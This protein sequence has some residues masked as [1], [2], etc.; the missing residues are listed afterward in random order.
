MRLL[1]ATL[2]AFLLAVPTASAALVYVKT[3]ASG[4]PTI[5][6][7][8]NDGS[9]PRRLVDGTQP[10]I[11]GD[12]ATVA[13]LRASGSRTEL[14]L[15]PTAGG[16]VRAL[17]TSSSI[18]S[19][20]FS[21]DAKLVAAEVG[22]RRLMVFETDTGRMGTLAT[23]FIKG[24]SFAPDSTRMVFGRGVDAT[25]RG[26]ADVYK[27]SV[28]GGP[29]RRL[30]RDGRSLLP[31]WGTSVIPA[32]DVWGMD[33]GGRQER[34]ITVTKVPSGVS[35]LLPIEWSADGRRLIAQYVGANV[36]V[37]F[38]INP[39]S[40]GT[41]SLRRKVAFDLASDGSAVLMQSGGIDPA[42]RHNVYAAPYAGGES[43]L[44]VRNASFPDWSR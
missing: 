37:G 35:G 23:G 10:Q 21:P 24:L 13:F 11:S 44:L 5:F 9:D 27:V 8:G 25:A 1:L 31:I 32:Y 39:N 12:G 17:V 20:T 33:V 28:R 19:V 29:A 38:T 3:P 16:P 18:E 41:R 40:G 30:T 42:A 22:G 14:A 34:R 7:A 2:V 4:A 43:E 36:R 15:I 6:A 26:T